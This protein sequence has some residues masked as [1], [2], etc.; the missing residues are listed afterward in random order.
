[1]K[2]AVK[3]LAEIEG[4][5]QQIGFIPKG[6]SEA[7]NAWLKAHKV[8]GCDIAELFEDDELIHVTIG[9]EIKA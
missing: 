6:H 1:D 8:I 4:K 7:V 2:N 5:F 9:M 3:I